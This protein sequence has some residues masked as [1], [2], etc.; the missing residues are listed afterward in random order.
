MDALRFDAL[1][2]SFA[3]FPAR[4]G[5]APSPAGSV[6]AGPARSAHRRSRRP[7]EACP[8]DR[9]ACDGSYLNPWVFG[10]DA[11]NC[12]AC[13]NVCPHGTVCCDG[14]CLDLTIDAGNCGACGNACHGQGTC[15]AGEC[16]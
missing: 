14:S 11:K 10:H 2:K 4:R 9:V 12:G 6:A 8:A 13:G 7:D 1:T 3:R 15:L 16:V 5:D